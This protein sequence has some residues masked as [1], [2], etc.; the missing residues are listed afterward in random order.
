MEKIIIYGGSFD[1]I[2]KGH[3]AI[4]ISAMKKINASKIFFV[5]SANPPA[6][7]K[8]RTSWDDRLMMLKKVVDKY[9]HFF[10]SE[11]ENSNPEISYTWKT[12]KHF[13]KKY[14]NAKLYF[15]MGSDQY[16]NFNTWEKYQ[17]ILDHCELI[18]HSRNGDHIK[19]KDLIFIEDNINISSTDSIMNPKDNLDPLVIDYINE[20]ALYALD[21][22][23]RQPLSDHRIKHSIEVAELAKIFA[24]N[25]DSKIIKQA[26]CAGIYHDI[27]KEIP[28]AKMI[29][30]AKT[31][32]NYD[33]YP[34]W[35]VIHAP[36]GAYILRTKFGFEDEMILNAIAFHSIPQEHPT[37]IDKIVFCADKLSYREDRQSN[38][39]L[40]S[41]CKE[42]I[43]KGFDVLLKLNQEW[44]KG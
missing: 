36:M 20:N 25:Y 37:I 31:L 38:N 28:Q 43:N 7:K 19:N 29:E 16:I 42:D 44:I 17:Y 24:K 23:R 15:L 18:C 27:A 40:I 35:K 14:Q 26:Y 6:S 9:D 1:P 10:I 22:L 41:L 21:R 8:H 5:L 3:I 30:D 4:A 2:H 13:Y 33:N 12:I 34:S 39:E 11:F 32:L